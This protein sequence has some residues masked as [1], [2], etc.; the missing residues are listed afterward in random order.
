MG[1]RHRVDVSPEALSRVDAHRADESPADAQWFHLPGVLLAW[2]LDESLVW[3]QGVT[4]VWLQV[5][6]LKDVFQ[7]KAAF[8]LTDAHPRMVALMGV[9]RRMMGVMRVATLRQKDVP[10]G[11]MTFLRLLDVP[12][13]RPETVGRTAKSPLEEMYQSPLTRS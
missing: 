8:L 3:P 9:R 6:T 11:A 2:L 4:Q 10:P 5:V 1:D 7:Q 12:G 13:L